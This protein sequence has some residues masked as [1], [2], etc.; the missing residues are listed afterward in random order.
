MSFRLNCEIRKDGTCNPSSLRGRAVCIAL[1]LS[2]AIS[3][4]LH[5]M[6]M[7]H[8]IQG[9]PSI[10]RS[11]KVSSWKALLAETPS[12]GSH[13]RRPP[14]VVDDSDA[15]K[16]V[17]TTATNITV[18]MCHKA[19]YGPV[20]MTRVIHWASY[21]YDLG[22]DR[23]FIWYIP[24]I[25][26]LPGFD[27]LER[28]PFVTLVPNLTGKPK[29]YKNSYQIDRG[30]PGNQLDDIQQCLTEIASGYDWVM[31]ADSDEFLWFRQHVGV[32]GF[33]SSLDPSTSY[34]SFGKW[35]Y[36]VRA[37]VETNHS[38]YDLN[39]VRGVLLMRTTSQ[40]SEAKAMLV[41]H[42]VSHSI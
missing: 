10:V 34:C 32:K 4:V 6:T 28:L 38:L 14:R 18:A 8:L 30:S 16:S 22:F 11:V 19:L 31:M 15:D 9:D 24:D 25:T 5:T 3:C 42:V 7:F 17:L 20:N 36:T 40:S 37:A 12:K 13:Q 26:T 21:Y 41:T 39:M 1:L 23:I 29:Q 33:L 35:M 27:E 2:L